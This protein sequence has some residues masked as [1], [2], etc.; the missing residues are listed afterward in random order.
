MMTRS[1][2]RLV[3]LALALL[4]FLAAATAV[5]AA[6]TVPGTSMGDSTRPITA[7]DLKPSQCSAFFVA[8]LVVGSGNLNGT[9][10]NDLILGSVGADSI[11]GRQGQ[12]CVLGGDGNNV[13]NGNQG[14]D[15]LMGG[16]GDDDIDG[17]PGAGDSC[18]AGGGADT[19]NRCEFIYP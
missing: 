17:G 16:A 13:L 11:D 6:N 18:Y 4:I 2:L 10:G 9:N 7:N 3:A 19:F 14:D 12:D 15:V 5:A 8:N 1:T